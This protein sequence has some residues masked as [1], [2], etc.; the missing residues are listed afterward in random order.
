MKPER[1]LQEF[2]KFACVDDF[3]DPNVSIDTPQKTSPEFLEDVA[4]FA[5]LYHQGKSK[6]GKTPMGFQKEMSQKYPR[7]W[8]YWVW[9]RIGWVY[10]GKGLEE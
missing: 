3:R 1:M 9:D 2:L 10:Y 7:E 6:D 4:M 8:M 5:N